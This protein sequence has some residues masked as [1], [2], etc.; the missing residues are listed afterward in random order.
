MRNEGVKDIRKAMESYIRLL[1]EG[2]NSFKNI[3]VNYFN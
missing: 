1:K 3:V 2:S